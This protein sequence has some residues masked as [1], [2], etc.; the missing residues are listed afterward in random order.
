[1][2]TNLHALIRYRALDTCFRER[3]RNKS[4]Q[5]LAAA[6]G[7]ALREYQRGDIKDP[8]RRT[9]FG[10]ID[11]MKN[12]RLG[13]HAPIAHSNALGYHYEDPHFSIEKQPL[14]QEHQGWLKDA[15][16]TLKQ[17]SWNMHMEGMDEMIAR[18]EHGVL[19]QANEHRRILLMDLPA[20]FTGIRWLDPLLKAIRQG[21]RIR[22]IY[23]PF[24]V[25]EPFS[26]EVSPYLL[27][28]YNGRWF[29]AGLDH[30]NDRIQNYGLDRIE[31]LT[32][33]DLP[34]QKSPLDLREHYRQVIG[35]TVHPEREMERVVFR[36]IP[37]QSFYISNKPVHHSQ[38][39]L[40]GDEQGTTFAIDVIPNFE[41]ESL[42][43]SFGERIEVLEPESLRLRIAERHRLVAGRYDACR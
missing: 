14:S 15:L 43:L 32:L 36:A 38:R 12:G 7:E 22:L 40:R 25:P 9:I 29:L 21:N 10:D 34:G 6:C 13:F 5:E 33:L 28:E 11:V 4:W 19:G 27:K 3:R 2:A 37:E 1:M 39:V 30:I 18:L 8:S 42:L 41:L 26:T 17:V 31:G 35:V 24:N 16:F 20:R 23:K